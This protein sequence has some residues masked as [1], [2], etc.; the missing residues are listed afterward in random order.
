[1]ERR[2]WF[3]LHDH[4]RY[5]RFL[6]DMVTDGL[7]HT[8]NTLDSYRS[9]QPLLQQAILESGASQV[10]D[11]CSGG[12][13]PWLSLAPGLRDSGGRPLPIMLTDRFPNIPAFRRTE[14][15]SGGRIRYAPEP[16]DAQKVPRQLAGFRTI[17]SSF[18]HFSPEQARGMLAD[19][20]RQREG[21]GVFE[22]ARPKPLTIS[23]C[24]AM[25][26]VN[27]L[28]TPA[29]RPLGWRRLL[30]TYVVP[31]IPFTLWFDGVL[32]CL[33]SYSQA[34]LRELVSPLQS[35]GYR[36]EIGEAGSGRAKVAYLIGV[37]AKSLY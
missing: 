3:E 7:E 26:V 33:R 12:G 9:I 6:R 36:W 32:S 2:P 24:F 20:F 18:H 14:Q 22:L 25:P 10:V 37:P 35:E 19:A 23:L 34:D 17:F 8:W 27:W 29:M 5:P 15:V 30:F 21:I 4:P 11:L 16:V 1:M 31:A 13:G 28:L